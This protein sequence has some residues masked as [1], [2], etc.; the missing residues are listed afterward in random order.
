MTRDLPPTKAIY[1]FHSQDNGCLYHRFL[2]PARFVPQDVPGLRIDC[3]SMQPMDCERYDVYG[4]H[5]L[6]LP[7]SMT[8]FGVWK[9]RGSKC[10]WS[11]DD[12]WLSV[13]DWN[14]AKPHP[15]VMGQYGLCL[16]ASDFI[17]AS[18]PH[19]ADTF[20]G[21]HAN[22]VLVAPNLMDLGQYPTRGPQPW[23]KDEKLRIVWAGGPTHARDVDV[24]VPA[25][26][27]I[28]DKYGNTVEVI[29]FGQSPPPKLNASHLHKGVYW[30][31]AIALNQY[32]TTLCHYLRPHVWLAPLAE[33]PFNRS[34]SAIRVYEGWCL[35]AAVLATPWGEYTTVRDGEDGFLCR[36]PEDW[37]QRLEELILDNDMREGMARAG[38]LRAE[39]E[40]DWNNPDCRRPWAEALS[41][42]AG[43]P[44][45]TVR[46]PTMVNGHA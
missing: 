25:L 44:A 31:P 42:I 46:T 30:H 1:L 38:R 36:D 35:S 10:L 41:K 8:R 17:L 32:W 21:R 6:V 23:P 26:Q 43:I 20:K 27:R 16:E 40:C 11:V 39:R 5:G 28:L 33:V 15:D 22:K 13:P 9:W 34:K 37:E 4:I 12:D 3:Q 2:C 19:L 14:P 18:T 24:V 7:D 29:F 45:D